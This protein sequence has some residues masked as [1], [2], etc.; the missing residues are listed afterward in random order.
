MRSHHSKHA[1]L[2]LWDVNVGINVIQIPLEVLTAQLLS[3]LPP[4]C[5][6]SKGLLET[7]TTNDSSVILVSTFLPQNNNN[8]QNKLKR[9]RELLKYGYYMR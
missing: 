1:R 9:R 7:K 2:I 8:K 6:V 5:H 4:L 3:K